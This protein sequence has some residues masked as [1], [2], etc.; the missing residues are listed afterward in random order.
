MPKKPKTRNANTMTEAAYW[1]MIR[2]ALR[3]MTFRWKPIQEYKKNNRAPY[4]GD[5]KR[6]KWIYQCEHCHK[7][8][9]DKE[10]HVDHII[11]AGSLRCAEDLPGFVERLYRE[12]GFQILCKPCHKEKTKAEKNSTYDVNTVAVSWV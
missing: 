6:Q 1:S 12:S 4:L 9:K 11:P 5:N 10:I 3:K 7:W 2:S 8:F